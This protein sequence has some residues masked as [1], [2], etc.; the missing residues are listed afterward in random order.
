MS[1]R[2]ASSGRCAR[3]LPVRTSRFVTL[4]LTGMSTTPQRGIS[5]RR[6]PSSALIAG[7]NCMAVGRIE[8]RT[9]CEVLL[10]GFVGHGAQHAVFMASQ[11][12]NACDSFVRGSEVTP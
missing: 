11:M 9:R 10:W 3:S 7:E 8:G 1:A 2:F 4:N 5:S 6:A 12:K